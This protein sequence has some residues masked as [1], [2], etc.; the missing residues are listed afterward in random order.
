MNKILVDLYNDFLVAKKEFKGQPLKHI[1]NILTELRVLAMPAVL[2]TWL[3]GNPI[4]SLTIATSAAATDFFDG[5]LARK[6]SAHSEFGRKLDTFADKS[7]T[8]VLM[9]INII[10]LPIFFLTMFMEY[11][12]A[13]VNLKAYADNIKTKTLEIGRVKTVFLYSTLL[14]G[15]SSFAFPKMLL[16]T[17][18]AYGATTILQVKT[19]DTYEKKYQAIKAEKKMQKVK[20]IIK[21]ETTKTKEFSKIMIISHGHSSIDYKKQIEN[22]K[23]IKSE[24]YEPVEFNVVNLND[25]EIKTR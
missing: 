19:L 3:M 4:L 16:P 10:K 11:N 22:L 1:P 7:L 13:K 21:E 15:I 25:E 17:I 20:P 9:G 2:V 14:L 23:K 18:I 6:M 8:A 5:F 24:I 12:I